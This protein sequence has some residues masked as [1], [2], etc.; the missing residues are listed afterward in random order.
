MIEEIPGDL[1]QWLRGFYAVAE[2]GGVTQATGAMGRE[3]PTI[4]RQIKSLEKE[5][6]VTLFDRF[7]GGMKLTPEGKILFEKAVAL[8]ED[9]QGIRSEFKKDF[10]E[11]R[12]NIVVATSHAIIDSFLPP[13]V[14]NFM[15]THPH[16]SFSMLGGVFERALAR[17][18]SGEADFGIAFTNLAPGSVICHDLFETGQKLIAPK[19][20]HF[21]SGKKPTLAQIA[22][23]PLIL[24]SQTGRIEPFIEKSFAKEGLSPNVVMTQNNFI[25]VKKY[26][27][28]GLGVALASDYSITP[29]DEKTMEVLSLD[30]YF[31]KRKVGLLLRKRK[32]LSP[33][34][35]A[36]LRTVKPGVSFAN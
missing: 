4:T 7:S 1:L 28:M 23:A 27:A 19:G 13:Y 34:V 22:A 8:F 5:L 15:Q 12:G 21:F 14:V 9:V 24:F 2:K 10:L 18:E 6:G 25:S 3:Q 17:I 33:A 36:F 26:V 16:V 31:P 29:E 32:Y 35:Q 30:R 20:H 11:Y